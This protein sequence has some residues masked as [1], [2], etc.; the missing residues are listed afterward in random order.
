MRALGTVLHPFAAR[1]VMDSYL[2]LPRASLLRQRAHARVAMAGPK[3]LGRYPTGDS[4]LPLWWEARLRRWTDLAKRVHNARR[5]PTV[6][7]LVGGQ[8]Q[9]LAIARESALYEPEGVS[10]VQAGAVLL[11]S[12]AMHVA[13]LTGDTLPSAPAR[14][15]L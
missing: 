11:G 1:D 13:A 9:H 3:A 14:L 2:S 10:A 12:T 6:A 7:P 4:M 5:R 8:L 15:F